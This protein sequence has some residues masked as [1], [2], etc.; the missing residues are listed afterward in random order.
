MV[1]QPFLLRS[2]L[3]LVKSDK[4]VFVVEFYERSRQW[5]ASA[6][7]RLKLLRFARA[8]KK[9]KLRVYAGTVARLTSR[10]RYRGDSGIPEAGGFGWRRGTGSARTRGHTIIRRRAN[11][12]G[13][14]EKMPTAKIPRDLSPLFRPRR[15]KPTATITVHYSS[16]AGRGEAEARERTYRA[17]HRGDLSFN[18]P[19]EQLARILTWRASIIECRS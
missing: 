4:G 17:L 6:S 2:R 15:V 12:T 8:I 13:E 7:R 14:W 11:G 3:Y 10:S 16:V 5:H 18:K 19:S 1:D 9:W